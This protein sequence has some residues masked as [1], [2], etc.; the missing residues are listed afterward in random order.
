[1]PEVYNE[2]EQG[3]IAAR[4]VNRYSDGGTLHKAAIFIF[5]GTDLPEFK[6]RLNEI[7]EKSEFGAFKAI[8]R[9][10]VK[11]NE[12]GSEIDPKRLNPDQKKRFD[13]VCEEVIKAVNQK[14]ESLIQE[15]AGKVTNETIRPWRSEAGHEARNTVLNKM[16]DYVGKQEPYKNASKVIKLSNVEAQIK[17]SVNSA[18]FISATNPESSTGLSKP[19]KYAELKKKTDKIG[20][21]LEEIVKYLNEPKP[22]QKLK[23]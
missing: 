9:D 10:W 18:E 5:T 6:K 21:N 23:K 20:E 8:F 13:T 14:I 17:N 15:R 12:L 4:L 7:I 1:M 16:L 11:G 2:Q 19:S 3:F 22:R